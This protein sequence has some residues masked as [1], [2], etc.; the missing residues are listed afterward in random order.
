MGKVGSFIGTI[1]S[2]VIGLVLTVLTYVLGSDYLGLN[3]IAEI[4]KVVIFPLLLLVYVLLAGSLIS[5]IITGV[6]SIF[7]N[8]TYIK[9][10]SILLL[11]FL[12]AL[13][14]FNVTYG[15]KIFLT[16]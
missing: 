5:G 15:V 13:I 3:G 6:I 2:T 4:G 9:I 1:I 7:S 8:V 16:L 11:I 10:T 12:I 14:G